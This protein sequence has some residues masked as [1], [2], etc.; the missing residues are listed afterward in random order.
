MRAISNFSL[1]A[2]TS[3]FWWRALIEL[4]IRARKSATGSVKLIVSF[5]SIVARSLSSR[6]AGN[7]R[8]VRP[9]C[10]SPLERT[11]GDV[12]AIDTASCGTGVA[13]RPVTPA[14]CLPHGIQSFGTL[15]GR[16]RNAGDLALERQFTEAQTAKSELADVSARTSAKLA[17]A[18]LSGRELRLL[19]R[20]SDTGCS[21][22]LFL[23]CAF[24][25]R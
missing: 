20:L 7:P 13:E 25:L 15:P 22:H 5:S 19:I 12:L 16:L 14:P 24:A 23:R 11:C 17:A 2:G 9:Y 1:E 10:W 3:T 6:Q 8:L 18:L 21:S 4:R